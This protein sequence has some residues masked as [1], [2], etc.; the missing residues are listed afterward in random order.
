MSIL[1]AGLPVPI[2]R[3]AEVAAAPPVTVERFLD[4]EPRAVLTADGW[5]DASLLAEG[6][7]V[8]HEVS[9][10]E[11]EVG[12][13]GADVE[14]ALFARLASEGL[15]LAA[16]GSGSGGSVRARRLPELPLRLR[17]SDLLAGRGLIGQALVAPRG[18]LDG[19]APG[20][21]LAVR[22]V[23]GALEV[24]AA[25][26]PATA[27]S[28]RAAAV[29]AA[30]AIAAG[31]SL[32]WFADGDG[33]LPAAALPSVLAGLLV[34]HRELLKDPLPPLERWLRLAGL[35]AFGGY[36]GL[37]GVS[38]NRARVRELSRIEEADATLALKALL[39]GSEQPQAGADPGARAGA[40]LAEPGRLLELMST[41]VEVMAYLAG[42]VERR[43][44]MEGV[45]FTDV[46]ERMRVAA[47]NVPAWRAL[48]ALLSARAA[49]GAGD[50]ETAE[51]EV[52]CALADRPDLR[53]ALM[54]AGEYAACR[55]DL[56]AAD[57][58]LR[59]A[60]HPVAAALRGPVRSLLAGTRSPAGHLAGSGSGRNQPC[61]CGSGRK[62]KV[63]CLSHAGGH[64]LAARAELLH[65][66]LSTF[67]QR[68][69]GMERLSGLV[70]RSGH[71]PQ[72][73]M[74]SLD[75]LL[76]WEGFTERF[77]RARGGWLRPDERALA[78]EWAATPI[79][80]YEVR[81][82]QPG[83]GVA[84][85]TLPDGEPVFLPDRSF[86]TSVRRLD[87]LCGR[88]LSDGT[89]P[90]I[91]SLPALVDRSRRG[92]LLELLAAA[93]SA[94]RLAEFFGPQPEPCLRNSDGHDYYDAAVTLGVPDPAAAWRR[95]SADPE[96]FEIDAGK[97]LD[98]LV[99]SGGQTTSRGTVSREGEALV[100][101]ANSLPRLA[102][103]E[104][105]VRAMVPAAWEA[106]R[107][108]ERLGSEPSSDDRRVRTIIVDRHIAPGGPGVTED[109]AFKEMIRE[110]SRTWVDT[111]NEQGVTPREAATATGAAHAELE[112]LLD[113]FQW[114]NDR[115]AEQGEPPLT[116]VDWIRRELRLPLP[117]GG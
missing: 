53:P 14:L 61:P 25:S 66:L 75:A 41:S 36:A 84:V 30:C 112:M 57:D 108:A 93:P 83:T 111:P 106:G 102:E 65:A 21:L 78:Q 67:A 51:R 86:S 114:R 15:P 64:P 32:Q 63:C 39:A 73:T 43:T 55:G 47:K 2:G 1:S 74:L 19:F 4:G 42:E 115:R 87:L 85:Q 12:V 13:L 34:T 10:I 71:N 16:G 6:V 116:D 40:D 109:A 68:A 104:D 27:D 97:K 80:A 3:L 38:W 81:Q 60:D 37:R 29:A 92:E 49:E 20:D 76:A 7:A 18:W 103:L 117:T 77:L 31:Q 23:G 110:W 79:V 69:A 100:L 5:V 91:L 59:R 62:R 58:Y 88:L 50:C 56:R 46:L 89:R 9:E 105:R 24:S 45:I 35:E 96:L 44:A 94:G 95:L 107:R 28:G 72:A 54:D 99:I 70:T 101:W 26:A 33:D 22:L 17:D 52:H 11:L 8:L 113:D 98:L 82:V 90:R 48:V